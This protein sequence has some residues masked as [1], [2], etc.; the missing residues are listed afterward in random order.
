MLFDIYYIWEYNKR[1]TNITSLFCDRT[2]LKLKICGLVFE[3]DIKICNELGIDAIGFLV[4]VVKPEGDTDIL[5]EEDAVKLIPHVKGNTKSVLLIKFD[6]PNYILSL[7]KKAKPDV[8]QLQK[9]AK[10]F[11]FLKR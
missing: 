3:E 11:I 6:D 7:I 10:V 4:K 8:V 9:E 2:M 5:L 1:E